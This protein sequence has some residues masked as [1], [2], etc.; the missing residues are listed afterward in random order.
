M[1]R[2][3]I[4]LKDKEL[5]KYFNQVHAALQTAD[6]YYTTAN[7]DMKLTEAIK[8]R[9]SSGFRANYDP[10]IKANLDLISTANSDLIAALQ[11]VIREIQEASAK[12]QS[13]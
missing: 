13:K 10:R 2:V 7:K 3:T 5:L 12:I 4:G 6:G 8:K 9:I 11:S 1:T